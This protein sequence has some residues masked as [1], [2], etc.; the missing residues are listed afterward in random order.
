[1]TLEQTR[2]DLTDPGLLFR[3]DVLADPRPLYA[4]LRAEA[5][6]WEM[7]GSNTFVVTSAD[8]V[9]E[10]VGR[11]DDFSSNLTSLVYRGADGRPCVFDMA[12]LGDAT[13]VLATADPPVHTKHRKLMGSRLTPAHVARL[14]PEVGRLV[15]GLLDPL[16]A[17]GGGDAVAA[18]ADPLPMQ[19][20]T[21]VIGLPVDDAPRLVRLVLDVGEI[22]AGTGDADAMTRAA[23]SAM[24]IGAYLGEHLATRIAATP[25]IDDSSPLLDV[26][27]DAVLRGELTDGEAVGILVQLASAGSE[28]TTSLIGTSI[29]HLADDPALQDELRADLAL[30]ERFLEEM[31]RLDGPFR[32]HYRSTP[33]DTEL[34]GVSIP[35][36]SRV[37]LMWAA[38]NL[39][40]RE[41]DHPDQLDLGRPVPKAHLAFGR[42]IHFC[43]GAPLARLEARV[44]IT[45]LLQRTRAIEPDPARPAAHYPNIFLRRLRQLGVRVTPA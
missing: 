12:P 36:G 37:L 32:F 43:I 45:H 44:A 20:L 5:P 13:H 26:L 2:Y 16:L 39:D 25:S 14:E 1:M 9:I 28:T 11:I 10:A 29:R 3:D 41:F 35:A 6:V 17:A 38:A 30:V 23:T 22:L 42:G 24:D 4:Q 19:V 21:R 7:P 40:E 33:H 27:A 31:L 15:D 18:L 8:L 34:G